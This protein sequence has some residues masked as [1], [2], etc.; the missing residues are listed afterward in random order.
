MLS[1]EKDPLEGGAMLNPQPLRSTTGIGDS[2]KQNTHDSNRPIRTA[3]WRQKHVGPD[4]GVTF[5]INWK[6][7]QDRCFSRT[8]FQWQL[9]NHQVPYSQACAISL[10]ARSKK[11]GAKLLISFLADSSPSHPIVADR[12]SKN[13]KFGKACHWFT[14]PWKPL[15][16]SP[17]SHH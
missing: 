3:D 16:W 7:K 10:F 13:L 1:H 12:A 9:M 4:L 2:I 15:S 8:C 5:L 17:L 11:P 14:D 6:W